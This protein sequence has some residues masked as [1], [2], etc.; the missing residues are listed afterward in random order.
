MNA[1]EFR[2]YIEQV[3]RQYRNAPDD[4]YLMDF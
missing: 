2:D 4:L 3:S 1:K